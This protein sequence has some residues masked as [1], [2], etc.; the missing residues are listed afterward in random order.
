MPDHWAVGLTRAAKKDLD[1]LDRQV[2][3]R[4]RRDMGTVAR[5]SA[6]STPCQ[7]RWV[8][9]LRHPQHGATHVIKSNPWAP[10]IFFTVNN[11]DQIIIVTRIST[12]EGAY[13]A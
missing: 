10:R 2:A 3:D 8:A 6:G 11:A 5:Q 7:H 12:R 4:A 13:L 1:K 9:K